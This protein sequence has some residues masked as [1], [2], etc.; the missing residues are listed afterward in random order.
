MGGESL[1]LHNIAHELHSEK[2][3]T[4][5]HQNKMNKTRTKNMKVE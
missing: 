4:G 1:I 2:K 5:A 3:V